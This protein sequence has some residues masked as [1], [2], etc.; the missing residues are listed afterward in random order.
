MLR[1]TTVICLVLVC[2]AI[3]L[4]GPAGLVTVVGEDP[5]CLQLMLPASSPFKLQYGAGLS[6]W[7]SVLRE[8]PILSGV[9]QLA[10]DLEG[11]VESDCDVDLSD[12]AV[13]VRCFT[14]D[15]GGTPATGCAPSDLNSNGA[16]DLSDFAG[17]QSAM[18][19]PGGNCPQLPVTV[20][21]EAL[22]VSQALGDQTIDVLI[23]P[24]GDS[25]FE[26]MGTEVVTNASIQT[27]ATSGTWG[28]PITVTLQPAIAPLAFDA[29]T[30]AAWTGIYVPNVGPASQPF[31]FS[32]NA[33]QVRE[34]DASSAVLLVGDG[35]LSGSLPTL[36]ILATTSGALDGELTLTL[37]GGQI[38]LRRGV[39]FTPT[40]QVRFL[41]LIDDPLNPDDTPA[42]GDE[43]AE[44]ETVIVDDPLNPPMLTGI[45]GDHFAI[46]ICVADDPQTV[47]ASPPTTHATIMTLDAAGGVVDFVS[48]VT[49]D[50][51]TEALPGCQLYRT[52]PDFPVVLVS[53]SVDKQ[54]FPTLTILHGVD[55]GKIVVIPGGNP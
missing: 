48:N 45:R 22:L 29:T 13:F 47:S 28:T 50:R 39:S 32:F 26:L 12:V 19:G 23:D 34:L 25:I 16:V 27:S 14:G 53:Q 41:D 36:Q 3:A 40:S 5:V 6:V 51:S 4:A 54:L 33:Q 10:P 18:N 7:D 20:F 15:A 21:V 38:V 37:V 31:T 44:I 30:T 52:N 17:V 24:D 11:D 43:L 2:S 55:G 42:F 46:E 9:A 8:N 35:T 1:N 49:F